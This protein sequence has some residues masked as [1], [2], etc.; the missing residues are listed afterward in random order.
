MK[1][2]EFQ[3]VYLLTSKAPVE[4]RVPKWGGCGWFPKDKGEKRICQHLTLIC[5]MIILLPPFLQVQVLFVK[6]LHDRMHELRRDLSAAG[7]HFRRPQ[8]RVCVLYIDES[9]SVD[10]QVKRGQSAKAFNEKLISGR[11]EGAKGKEIE[12][13]FESSII[14]FTLFF[15]CSS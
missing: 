2:K 5:L 7:K 15:L 1:E 13:S 10:R 12:N 3:N 14:L 9:T 11:L 8:F 4:G 6:F